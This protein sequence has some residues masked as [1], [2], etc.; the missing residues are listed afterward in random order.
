MR[1]VIL[2]LVI[3]ASLGQSI[4]AADGITADEVRKSIDRGVEYLKGKQNK[5]D[6][7]WEEYK[8]QPGGVTALCT[9][10]LLN[11]G[12]DPED[13]SIQKAL[14]F[15]RKVGKP[16][17]TYAT[18][19]QIMAF[20]AA[21]PSPT[22]KDKAL[23]RRNANYLAAIQ[24][25]A[26]D[27]KGMW[28]YSDS[29]GGG[30]NSNT[31]FAL[32]GLYEAERVGVVVRDDVWTLA[33]RHWLKSQKSNGGW[34]YVQGEATRGSMTCAGIA[35]LVICSGKLGAGDA[36]VVGDSVRC[37]GA[38]DA[39]DPVTLAIEKGIAW[40][41][42]NRT[43]QYHPV[44]T[45]SGEG[46]DVRAVGAN[47][48]LYYLYGM[49]RVGR[50]TGERYFVNSRGEKFDWYREGAEHIVRKQDDFNGSWKGV[51]PGEDEPLVATSF[52]LL[53]LSK[54]RRPV[55][56]GKL[57]REPG[58]DWNYHSSSVGNLTRH[59]ERKWGRDLTWQTIISRTASPED[60]LQ[61][62]VLFISGRDELKFS[63][64]EIESLKA[65]VNA[66]GFIFAEACCEGARFDRDFRAL[67]KELFPDGTLRP[68]PA[69]HP[70]WF[71][72]TKV[73]PDPE[74]TPLLGLNS[75]CRTSV[76]YCPKNLSCYWELAKTRNADK[77][78]PEAVQKR[79]DRALAIG[80]NV[81]AYATGREL[82]DKLDIP[83]LV[84]SNADDKPLARGTLDVAKLAH[85]GGSDDAPSALSN[86][87]TVAQQEAGIAAD[88]R[89]KPPIPIA[90]DALFNYPIVFMHGRRA[91]R[92]SETERNHLRQYI[93]R[94][95]F[96]FA[97]AICANK[98]FTES[99]HRE[100]AG[101]FRDAELREIPAQP[102]ALDPRVPRLRHH[103]SHPPG[104]R[105]PRRRRPAQGENLPHRPHAGRPGNRRPPG[106]DLL[107]LRPKLRFG[108]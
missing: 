20:V 89:W 108:E 4:R 29:Q 71:A 86:L 106:G 91:F 45:V 43:V 104:P 90:G 75:C 6:G 25:T 63:P 11:A 93:E 81:L 97:D 78:Y 14:G 69:D 68:L 7:N 46:S 67:M 53:F 23:I 34:A 33:E 16:K 74:E 98:A 15:L 77:S 24:I 49:E 88:T 107:A 60:L 22:N 61:T 66:G 40:M 26:E 51:G 36:T 52:A 35:S 105:V 64:R 85:G 10:A 1:N 5:V 32:L 80:A 101:I 39:D 72:E 42:R 62:P 12:V 57:K 55:V 94:G 70:I 56:I 83:Q 18:S 96:L 28:S 48:L 8:L 37:C 79:V 82:R 58:D 27:R 41:G 9:L 31:Q 47:W 76:V 84:G 59:V 100:I 13:A 38:A 19:L 102:S 17:M 87:L 99:F 3:I 92:L 30:D 95:G 103:E 44:E 50:M 54:G 65:Y 73:L 2:S 21:D